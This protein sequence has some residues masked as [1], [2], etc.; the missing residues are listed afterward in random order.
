MIHDIGKLVEETMRLVLAQREAVIEAFIAETGL[1]PSECEQVEQTHTDG[2]KTWY[3]RKRE[4]R[5]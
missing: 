1:L 4:T 3:V 5:K 2:T